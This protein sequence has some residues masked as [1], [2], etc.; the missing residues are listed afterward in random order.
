MPQRLLLR[1]ELWVQ[2][3][4]KAYRRHLNSGIQGRKCTEQ[5][6]RKR[7]SCWS[8]W[9]VGY[10]RSA[11]N[12]SVGRLD[13]ARRCKSRWTRH[14]H[15][16][17]LM[18]N[19]KQDQNSWAVRFKLRKMG[20]R[21]YRCLGPLSMHLKH[22]HILTRAQKTIWSRCLF[23]AWKEVHRQPSLTITRQLFLSYPLLWTASEVR[24]PKTTLPHY[25]PLYM[26]SITANSSLIWWC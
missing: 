17:W 20:Q 14:H 16:E 13:V 15:L 5:A 18:A 4:Y 24:L 22:N 23:R 2:K 19:T 3:R 7:S 9:S 12:W 8:R 26:D 21:M 6:S 1:S 11:S 10:F 25:D